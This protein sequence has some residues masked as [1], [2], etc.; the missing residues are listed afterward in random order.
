VRKGPLLPGQENVSQSEFEAIE[1]AQLTELWSEYGQLAETWFDGG[2]APDML[3]ALKRLITKYLPD[4]A[5]FG[6]LGVTPN[7]VKWVGTEVR[8][9]CTS[10][11]HHQRTIQRPHSD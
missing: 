3:P 5:A 11:V 2:W 10:R 9:E 6:G 1:L 4:T 8:Y 7:A